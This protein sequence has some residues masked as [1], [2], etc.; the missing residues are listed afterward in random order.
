LVS[1]IEL[2]EKDQRVNVYLEYISD[3]AVDSETGD[4]CTIYDHRE[5]RDWHHLDTM[6]YQ[7]YLHARVPRVKN[8][9]GNVYTI[10]VPWA[11]RSQRH[12]Y[13]LE[14]NN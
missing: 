14:K 6:Q 5:E 13:L 1:K 3:K 4:I 8:R 11:D 10:D 9:L 7:T 12:T 2:E